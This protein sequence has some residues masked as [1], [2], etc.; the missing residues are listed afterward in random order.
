[1]IMTILNWCYITFIAFILGVG[2][3]QIIRKS[4]G[5]DCNE[6]DIILFTGIAA[7]TAYAQTFSVFYKVGALANIVL[8]VVC[9]VIAILFRSKFHG[10]FT[11]VKIN[12]AGRIRDRK[13]RICTGMLLV[14]FIFFVLIAIQRAYH[15][16]TDLYHA[17]SIRWIEEYG[18]VKGSG[19]FYH[20]LAYNSAFM[21]FQALFSWAFLINQS[22]HVGN[23]YLC[24]AV[25]CYALTTV[26]FFKGTSMRGSD[27]FKIMILLY[28]CMES[29]VSILSSPNTNTFVLVLVLY[30]LAKWCE[31]NEAGVDRA[32][33]Y[34][35]LCLLG[36]FALTVKLTA[37]ITVLLT[38]R[39]AIELLSA[40]KWK[41]IV[42]YIGIGLFILVPFCARNVIISG[43]LVYPYASLDFF[44]VDWK[45]SPYSV[46]YDRMQIMGRNRGIYEIS[47]YGV[48]IT[49]W[50]P[51]W[52]KAQAG[53]IKALVVTNV[54]LLPV[55][56][57]KCVKKLRR[58]DIGSYDVFIGVT[59][60]VQFL[61]W[62][63]TVPSISKGM[64][65]PFVVPCMLL[66][67]FIEYK[68][69]SAVAV[70]LLS[71]IM[72]CVFVFN[73]GKYIEKIPLKRSSYYVYRECEE[74]QWE[75]MTVY[76]GIE[77]G[78]M[79]YYYMPGAQH[80]AM[81]KYL[82]L[83]GSDITDGFRIKEEY[84]DYEFDTSGR[85]FDDIL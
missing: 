83:R 40:K 82:E 7:V 17:Q 12:L 5:Y 36:V 67:Y 6:V 11:S 25:G 65:F 70:M 23:A 47:R 58:K 28:L 4:T 79:G 62:M 29:V 9:F 33:A 26:S 50:F 34:G 66:A 84:K 69:P 63:L 16:D 74:I 22:M 39:P 2:V 27:A 59:V 68:K 31:Y 78:Y 45:M 3:M 57:L 55:C 1:M 32:E 60:V 38:I 72:V 48:G 52:W 46:D 19:N 51:I 24:M 18:A 64:I 85:L 73:V 35:N 53:W 20:R 14:F 76:K 37:A 77:N 42:T 15:A 8:L 81:L 21:C 13:F 75:G 56:L 54:I 49:E 61:Y 30:I 71:G 43:Y 41:A 80:S 44:N 10:I